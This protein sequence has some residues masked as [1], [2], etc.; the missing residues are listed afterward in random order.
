MASAGYVYI[1]VNQSMPG[2]IKI[3]RTLRDSRERAR[4]LHTTGVPT[5]FEVVYEVF[6]EEH[7]L[8]EERFKREMDAYKVAHNREFF[9]LPLRD[10]ID[11]LQ[12]LSMPPEETASEFAAE[13]IFARLSIKYSRWLK[14]GIVD[15][16]IVQT[17]NRVWLEI[18]E[19]EEIAGYLVDRT[20]TRADMAFCSDDADEGP[21]FNPSDSVSLNADKFIE[22]WTPS[23]IIQTTDLFHEEACR[24]VAGDS[25]LDSFE[26]Q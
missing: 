9:R 12:A 1:L 11:R 6:V 24:E 19:E 7:E 23:S 17:K 4:E 22:E 3:G 10:A 18:T 5:P 25:R 14:P 2:M 16:R 21:Y 15:V 8:V 13:S 20:I 26:R